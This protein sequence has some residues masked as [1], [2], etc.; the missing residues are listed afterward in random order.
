MALDNCL[1]TL[2]C[3][4]W[5]KAI[6]N[7][8]YPFDSGFDAW[9]CKLTKHFTYKYMQHHASRAVDHVD[10]SQEIEEIESPFDLENTVENRQYVLQAM[11]Q[12][13][14][15]QREVIWYIYFEGWSQ[16]QIADHFHVRIDAI[17]K[18]HFDA[19]KQLRKILGD[20]GDI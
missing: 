12:L 2:T 19:L 9:S 14:Q 8:H 4:R 1:K 16:K 5:G 20:N 13:T 7:A 6:L 18:R 3:N 17:Y 15:N 10:F 11:E